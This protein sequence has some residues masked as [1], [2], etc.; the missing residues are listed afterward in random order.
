MKET[1]KLKKLEH[2][3]KT[4]IQ[5]NNHKFWFYIDEQYSSNIE[6]MSTNCADSDI[7]KLKK[8]IK[9]FID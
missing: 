8:K 4:N 6:E 7:N 5:E 1:L 9:D 3:E 2:E